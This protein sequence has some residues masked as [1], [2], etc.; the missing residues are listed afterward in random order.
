MN[1]LASLP[2]EFTTLAIAIPA[3]LFC[4]HMSGVFGNKIQNGAR[5]TRGTLLKVFLGLPY[6]IV[7]I[8]ASIILWSSVGKF[9]WKFKEYKGWSKFWVG[10][11]TI[12][13]YLVIICP[14]LTYL[15]S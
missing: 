8:V 4:L 12:V 11:S 15:C 13:L 9:V 2:A 10:L 1:I 6:Y 14:L 5:K 7:A 3:M